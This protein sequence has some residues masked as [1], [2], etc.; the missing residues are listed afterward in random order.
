[1]GASKEG[2]QRTSRE[3][4]EFTKETKSGAILVRNHRSLA[5][6]RGFYYCKK[7]SLFLRCRPLP[8]MPVVLKSCRRAEEHVFVGLHS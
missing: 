5:D 4:T 3:V 6:E 8:P 7:M 1:M 2:G